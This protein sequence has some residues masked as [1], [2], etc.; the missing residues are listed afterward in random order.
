MSSGKGFPAQPAVAVFAL[1]MVGSVA[2]HV[3]AET[4]RIL[5]GDFELRG[6]AA[7]QM[8]VVERFNGDQAVGQV[9][10]PVRWTSSQPKIVQISGNVAIPQGDGEATITAEIP[11]AKEL[12]RVRVSGTGQPAS[13][14]FR[15]HVQAVLAKTGCNSGACHGAAAGKNGFRLSLR[16]FD[17][18]GDYLV[19]TH[20]AKGRRVRLAD[21]GRSLLLTKPSG[22]LSH[23]GGRRFEP[24]SREYA[25]LADWI[26]DGAPAPLDSDPRIESLHIHPS[27]V[28]LSSGA[29]QQFLVQ[30]RFSDGRVEDVTP[31]VKYTSSR[32]YVATIDDGGTA[33][34]VGHGAGAITA[35][36]LNKIAIASV[37]VPYPAKI[38]PAVFAGA[39]RRNWI[40]ELVL[41]KLQ[42]L[43]LPPSPDASDAEF[44][45]R[46][47]LDTIG[48]LPKPE[49]T[50]AFLADTNAAKRDRVIAGLLER[51]EF[52]DYWTYKFCDLFL[53]SSEKLPAPALWSYYRWIRDNV[54]AN[55]P[56]DLMCRRVMTARGSTLENGAGNFYVL[57]QDPLELTEAISQTFL[58]MSINCARCHNHPLE[59][60]SNAQYYGMVGLV[61]RVRLKD[62]GGEG[63]FAVYGDPEG[64]IVRPLSGRV[65]PPRP[66]D[67]D[68]VPDGSTDRREALA[69]WVTSPKNPYF[70]RAI[71]NRIWANFF[72]VGIVEKVDD[73]R[74]TNPASNEK[75]LAALADH[76]V[77]AK[78]D[79]RSLVRAILESKTYQRASAP[80]PENAADR[81]F[82]SRYY[83][84]RLMAEVL[85]DAIVDVTGVPNAFKNYP[86]GWRALQLPDNRV[87]SYFLDRFGRPER[88][89]VCECERTNEPN[90]VQVLHLSNGGTIND[91]LE[92]PNNV[93]GRQLAAKVPI[94]TIMEDFYLRALSRFPTEPEKVAFRSLAASAGPDPRPLLEDLA[95]AILG[96]KDFL[97]NH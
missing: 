20:Q 58:G 15:N 3:G 8:L 19:L 97:F 41:A 43:N 59:K 26:A 16:G 36:Y 83:P 4:V 50:R 35:W 86:A 10:R 34:I 18:E 77:Q 70:A 6:P 80:R 78:F 87:E 39:T 88:Q 60:W 11:G 85:V 63:N 75:L 92:A 22:L 14:S 73:L 81:R 65:E 1:V 62:L 46:V 82:Y 31:W 28:V 72:S 89:N 17:A 29:R 32:A 40:D 2:A 84:R 55:T 25:V 27:A 79:L 67:A 56:W 33:T 24:G 95:W 42:E 5:P 61:A 69:A 53:V 37:T 23:G 21:P 74:L 93:L 90:M 57:H 30:A 9:D 52:V 51:P 96:S 13:W 12:V 66:L 45:R 76:L 91:K 68:T 94:E 44:F 7:R 64:E 47:H 38:D 49:A 54:E 71:A 48:V